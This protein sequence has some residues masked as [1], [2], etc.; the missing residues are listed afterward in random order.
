MGSPAQLVRLPLLNKLLNNL[1]TYIL[2]YLL[3]YILNTAVDERV[4][5]FISSSMIRYDTIQ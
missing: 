5:D 1:L 4:Y 3:T 2:T